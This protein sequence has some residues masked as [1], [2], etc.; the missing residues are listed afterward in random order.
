MVAHTVGSID[1]FLLAT[2]LLIFALGLYELFIS[3]IDEAQIEQLISSLH[4]MKPV[5]NDILNQEK[6]VNKENISRQWMKIQNR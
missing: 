6:S 4:G 3:D 1:G 2:I 5:E